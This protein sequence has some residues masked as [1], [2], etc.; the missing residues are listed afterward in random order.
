MVRNAPHPIGETTGV[1][2]Q[3]PGTGADPA[4]AH[5]DFLEAQRALEDGGLALL[6][7][8]A[9]VSDTDIKALR[10][11][12]WTVESLRRLSGKFLTSSNEHMA[13]RFWLRDH[14]T[15]GGSPRLD[16][17]SVLHR[18]SPLLSYAAWICRNRPHW[19]TKI[20]PPSRVEYLPR[21]RRRIPI[22]ASIRTRVT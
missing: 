2:T 5:C 6:K 18:L 3:A 9:C 17:R 14:A 10:C 21:L 22:G 19:T 1:A 12:T 7:S 13:R 15:T 16:R 4:A 11:R 8:V 20:P